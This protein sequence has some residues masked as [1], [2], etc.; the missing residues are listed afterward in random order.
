MHAQWFG[1]LY[2]DTT[3]STIGFGVGSYA[4]WMII[5]GVAV[6][7]LGVVLFVV[8]RNRT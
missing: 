7:A 6:T 8:L 1:G 4:F 5:L 3:T 2:V